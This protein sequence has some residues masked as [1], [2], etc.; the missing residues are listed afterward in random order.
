MAWECDSVKLGGWPIL[1][2]NRICRLADPLDHEVM[3]AHS[4]LPIASQDRSATEDCA[5]EVADLSIPMKYEPQRSLSTCW[6]RLT[7]PSARSAQRS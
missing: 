5:A 7:Y 3:F 2:G 1:P 6:T 4:A